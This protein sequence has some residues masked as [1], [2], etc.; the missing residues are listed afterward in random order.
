MCNTGVSHFISTKLSTDCVSRDCTSNLL[1]L[2]KKKLYLSINIPK[3]K[4]LQLPILLSQ[5]PIIKKNVLN[6]SLLVQ[7]LSN[8]S[9][10]HF[11]LTVKNAC[12]QVFFYL[13]QWSQKERVSLIDL[14]Y[15]AVLFARVR[16][17]FY[18]LFV[19]ERFNALFDHRYA[20]G[21]GHFR[22]RTH[23]QQRFS[24]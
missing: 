23:L 10:F 13:P 4:K 21:K 15:V 6:G 16:R 9:S 22:L 7:N 19:D 24:Q 20:R 1:R 17:P 18:V 11:L 14:R 5:I 12:K 2:S 3:K 8:H